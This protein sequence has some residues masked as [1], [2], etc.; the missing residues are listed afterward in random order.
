MKQMERDMHAAS[1]QNARHS[2]LKHWVEITLVQW[3]VKGSEPL[4]LTKLSWSC[5]QGQPWQI[6]R[7]R[8]V[9]V[10]SQKNNPPENVWSQVLDWTTRKCRWR[11]IMHGQ[12]SKI[13]GYGCDRLGHAA[14]TSAII[15]NGVSMLRSKNWTDCYNTCQKST[16]KKNTTWW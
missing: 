1:L 15:E 8:A 14:T 3:L 11:T 13:H 4:T 2:N 16:Y 12:M 7:C 6:K 9:L 10:P 5:G